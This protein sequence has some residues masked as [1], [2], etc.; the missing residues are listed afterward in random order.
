MPAA[1]AVPIITAGAAAGGTVAAGY[2]QG[3]GARQAAN[4][5]TAA[6]NR[7][8]ELE[9]QSAREALAFAK[10]QEDTRRREWQST[11]DRNFQL[12]QGREAQLQPY[13]DFGAGS[14]AQL[15]RPRPGSL[16]DRVGVQ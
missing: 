11:Q 14:L 5:Q 9:A 7:A 8:A 15:S 12:W 10:E 3:R 4:V 2:M 6:A 13:R 1:V 16:G